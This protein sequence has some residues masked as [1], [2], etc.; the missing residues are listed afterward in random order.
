MDPEHFQHRGKYTGLLDI[1]RDTCDERLRGSP[2]TGEDSLVHRS[3]LEHYLTTYGSPELPPLLMVET[4]TIGQLASA[5]RNLS[6]RADRTA[7]ARSIGLTAPVLESWAAD[8][9]A[10]EDSARTTGG[11]GT[12]ASASTRQSRT[13]PRSRG[14]R[15]RTLCQSG[16]GS[17]FTLCWCRCSPCSTL[18]LHAA[19]GRGGSTSC[20]APVHG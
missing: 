15:G 13:R 10:G 5:Y 14:W 12:S 1:V 7:V 11:C 2:D 20:S 18:C 19:V 9:R 6:R 3:A 8:L 4:L 17:A 16:R